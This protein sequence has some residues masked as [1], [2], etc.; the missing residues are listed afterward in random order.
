VNHFGDYGNEMHEH[1]P[2]DEATAEALLRGRTPA[3]RQ[4][5]VLLAAFVDEMRSLASVPPPAPSAVLASVLASG[6]T[7]IEKGDLPATAAS[8]VHGPARQAAGLPKWRKRRMIPTLLSGIAAKLAGLGLAAKAGLGL[9]MAVASVTA[10]GAAGVLPDPVQH[11]VAEAVGAVTPFQFPDTGDDKAD[12]GGGI[13]T[14]ATDDDEGVDGPSIADE[15]KDQGGDLPADAGDRPA[16]PGV[17][18]DAGSQG[19]DQANQTPAADDTP[20]SVP[21]G[22]TTA[23]QYRPEPAPAGPGTAEQYTPT[24]PAGPGTAEQYTP[25]EPAGP[26][27][28][29]QYTPAPTDSPGSIPSGQPASVPAGRP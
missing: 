27:T 12:F 21:A 29:E 18:A 24:E 25:T 2:L 26:G 22:P 23:D 9:S 19:I 17:P 6:L 1:R 13:S 11:A 16:E 15:A 3:G 20:S 5:L 28:A 7:T 8:N 4:D 10:A 14:D